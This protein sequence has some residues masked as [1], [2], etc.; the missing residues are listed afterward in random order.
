[1]VR[2]PAYTWLILVNVGSTVIPY[3]YPSRIFE[4]FHTKQDLCL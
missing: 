3:M 4:L 1:M 2:L